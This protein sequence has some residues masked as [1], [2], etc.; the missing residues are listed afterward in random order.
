MVEMVAVVTGD[1]NNGGGNGGHQSGGNSGGDG[2]YQQS[3]RGT[4][5]AK[6]S[7]TNSG[8]GYGDSSKSNGSSG[9]EL[10]RQ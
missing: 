2:V 5:M 8:C 7:C 6:G 10:W 9:I 1:N 4:V 3:S